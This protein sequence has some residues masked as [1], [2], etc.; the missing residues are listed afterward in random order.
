LIDRTK[1]TYKAK[2]REKHLTTQDKTTLDVHKINI[3][4]NTAK[5]SFSFFEKGRFITSRF[6]VIHPASA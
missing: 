3:K 2:T 1:Q 4:T 6:D 5:P